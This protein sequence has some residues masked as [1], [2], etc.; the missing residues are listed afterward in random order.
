MRKILSLILM[1]LPHLALA[2]AALEKRLADAVAE[3]AGGG[4]MMI[5][6]APTRGGLPGD[7]GAISDLRYEAKSARF[8]ATVA[9]A[10]GHAI[11]LTGRAFPAVEVPVLAHSLDKGA[12][13]AAA[14]IDYQLMRADRLTAMI[15]TDDAGL[16]GQAAR[17]ALA[18]GVALRQVDLEK[19]QVVGKG[20]LVMLSL[21]APGISLSLRG[22]ALAD[23][24]VGDL[25][26]VANLTSNR[27][28]AGVIA[29]PGLVSVPAMP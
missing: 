3:K 24:A 21:S 20:D 25:I 16:I 23:G 15:I 26:R 2:D 13:I 8:Y 7:L 14:D 27:V 10:D 19:P 28:V 11:S 1:F 4:Q 22:R 6:L 18:P 9:A 12:V 17:R 29:G 5:E